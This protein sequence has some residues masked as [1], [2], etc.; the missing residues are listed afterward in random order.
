M[1][2]EA[3][4]QRIID[5]LRRELDARTAEVAEARAQQTAT[6]EILASISG[7]ITNPAPVFEAVLDNLLRLFGTRY[8]AIF[9][10]RDGML[11]AA[12]LKGEPG[13][14]KLAEHYPVPVDERLLPGKAIITG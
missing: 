8:A 4:Q 10:V 12:G 9:L 11:H 2:S 13:F 1:A 14:E 5:E 3:D 7:S 6:A